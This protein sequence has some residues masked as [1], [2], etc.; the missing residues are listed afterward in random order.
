MEMSL[1]CVRIGVAV[2]VCSV[3]VDDGGDCTIGVFAGR[4]AAVGLGVETVNAGGVE[5]G[6][7]VAVGLGAETVDTDGVENDLTVAVGVKSGLRQLA[8]TNRTIPKLNRCHNFSNMVF[9]LPP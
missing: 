1:T 8:T 2:L 9:L 4:R 5:N 6:A 3:T 7:T